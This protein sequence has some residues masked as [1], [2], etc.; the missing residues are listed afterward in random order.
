[1][2]EPLRLQIW[3]VGSI[4]TDD[5][6]SIWCIYT[7]ED[8]SAMPYVQ[9]RSYNWD[10]AAI[11][12]STEKVKKKPFN[13]KGANSPGPDGIHPMVLKVYADVLT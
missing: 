9:Q 4:G 8:I 5:M 3:E 10:D 2:W 7:P 6:E 12:F 1:M 13:L 11:N